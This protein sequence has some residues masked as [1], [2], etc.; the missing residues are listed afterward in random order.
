MLALS[1]SSNK[2]SVAI[3]RTPVDTSKHLCTSPGNIKRAITRAR[4]HT[5][6]KLP[7]CAFDRTR[8]QSLD[9]F[10][11]IVF[12]VFLDEWRRDIGL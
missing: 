12:H 2:T 4:L 11:L 10:F 5:R 1:A 3:K 7:R 9:Q 6:L 8:K